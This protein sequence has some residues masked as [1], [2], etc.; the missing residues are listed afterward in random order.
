MN[1]NEIVQLKSYD[2]KTGQETGNVLPITNSEAV[3]VKNNKK[4]TEILTELDNRI[5][6]TNASLDN[7][8]INSEK[9]RNIKPYYI[10]YF[11]KISKYG[12]GIPVGISNYE[13]GNYVCNITGTKGNKEVTVTNGNI[14]HG[15][16]TW[17]CVIQDDKLNTYIN[18]VKSTDGNKFVLYD[19]LKIDITSGKIGCLFDGENSIHLSELGYYAFAQVIYNTKPKYATREVGE[20]SFIGGNKESLWKINSSWSSYD[21]VEN[22]TNNEV[23]ISYGTKNLI[24]NLADESHNAILNK[25]V[26]FDGYVEIY[27]SSKNPCMLSYFVNGVYKTNFSIS[28]SVSRV[29]LPFKKLDTIQIKID[30]GLATSSNVNQ[31][32]ISKSIFFESDNENNND[33]VI[34]KNDKIVYIGDSWGVFH[35]NATVR[36]LERLIGK[37]IIN[38]S[39]GGH[40]TEYA[41]AWIEEVIKENPSKVIIEYFTNDFNSIGGTDLGTFVKPDGT[42]ASL[43]I[44]TK[45]QYVSNIEYICEQLIENGIQPIVCMVCTPNTLNQAQDFTNIGNNIFN[46]GS[47]KSNKYNSFEVNKIQ[48]LERNTLNPL[49]ID[50]YE[51]NSATRKGVKIG[52]GDIN[53]TNGNVAT[54]ENNGVEV[55]SIGYDGAFNGTRVKMKAVTN[56]ND[57]PNVEEGRG[58]IYFVDES[59]HYG[60]GDNFYVVIKNLD[61]SYSRKKILLGDV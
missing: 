23:Y 32:R 5:D 7:I 16:G 18:R 21:N 52:S 38:Y 4:L 56:Y 46:G 49:E 33:S 40:S 26:N 12:L 27:V 39:K 54:F 24:F 6:Q 60:G 9:F 20:D 53:C 17:V 61:G 58:T 1:N 22:I 8:A 37:S 55:A 19:E 59:V 51:T 14:S 41:K 42:S 50:S 48:Q 43:N 57:I 25:I 29:V 45:E 3:K 35:N 11:S 31:V 44:S 36:E 34:N 28:E 47:N 15:G 13:G 30:D 10:E 2:D